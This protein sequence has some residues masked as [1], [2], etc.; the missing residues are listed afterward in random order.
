M[1]SRRLL[2]GL[3]LSVTMVGM[4]MPA[5]AITK[6]AVSSNASGSARLTDPD[7][8]ADDMVD[9]TQR[10]TR[11]RYERNI[12]SNRNLVAPSGPA[13]ASFRGSVLVPQ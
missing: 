1:S 6:Q 12:M 7:A 13:A 9:R 10:S 2:T 8:R 3:Y 5:H 4:T 11:R